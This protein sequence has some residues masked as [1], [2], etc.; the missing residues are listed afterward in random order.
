MSAPELVPVDSSSIAAVGYDPATRVLHVRFVSGRAY[1]Y[2][3]V[4]PS[5]YAALL[6]AESKGAYFNRE[7]RD[8]FRFTRR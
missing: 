3:D 4:P 2:H 6:R 5:T 1:L 7:V 8:A